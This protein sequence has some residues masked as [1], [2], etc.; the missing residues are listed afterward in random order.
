MNP[1]K[2]WGTGLPG[3]AV[4]IALGMS[5]ALA[6]TSARESAAAKTVTVRASTEYDRSGFWRT[7]FGDLWRD[8]W[9][10]E[11]TVP[12]LDLDHYAGGLT[13]LKEGGNQSKT[14]RF[15]GGDGRTYVFRSTTKR[16]KVAKGVPGGSIAQ[17]QTASI[18]PTGTLAVAVLQDAVGLLQA[19]PAMVYM[20]DDSRLGEFQKDFANTLGSIEVRPDEYE[21]GTVF[22][23]AKKIVGNESLLENLE[24]STEDRLDSR[25]YLKA[26]LIDFLIGDT[27][28]GSDQWSFAKF[29]LGKHDVYR[30]IPKDHDYAFLKVQGPIPAIARAVHP[31]LVCF[32]E[33][34]PTL[35]SLCYMTRD[36]DRS[37]LVDIEWDEWDAIAAQMQQQLGDD[38]IER[39]VNALPAGHRKTSGDEIAAALKARRDSLRAIA[40]EFYLMVN[41]EADI[42]ASD[43]NEQVDIERHPDGSVV[44]RLWH[45]SPRK[46]PDGVAASTRGG[47][48]DALAAG[49]ERRF[50]PEETR[51]IR[52]YLERGDDRAIV[53]GESER[54]IVV[55]VAGGEGDDVLADSSRV[56]R[57]TVTHFYDASGQN[58]FVRGDHTRI[59]TTPFVTAPPEHFDEEAKT[60]EESRVISEER[61]GRQR[62]LMQGNVT[63]LT[64]KAPDRY[65]GEAGRWTPT[66]G[67]RESGG[68]LLG[69]GPVY[70]RYGFRRQ[71]YAWRAG[72]HGLVGTRTGE[73][74]V[75]LTADRYYDSSRWSLALLTHATNLESNRFYGYG[76]DTPLLD[77][78]LTLVERFELLVKPS[79]RYRLGEKSS[80]EFGPVVKYV[81]PQL[82][83]GSPAA[84]ESPPGTEPFGQVGGRADLVLDRTV[85]DEK[86]QSGFG[87]DLGASAYPSAWDA[88][89][90]F[91][92]AHALARAFV[93]LGW[94]TLALRAGG[95]RSWG[96]FPLHESA[97][98]GGRWTVRGFRWNRFAGD[99][100]AF[101]SVELRVPLAS[102]KLF[103]RGQLG[104]LG[105]ADTGRVWL[106]GESDGDW[107]TGGGG[108][109]WFGNSERQASVA[110][111]YGDEHRIYFYMG[112]PF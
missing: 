36:F 14:L 5:P 9:S 43:E 55:R 66:T 12:V 65:W 59:V 102:L 56:G 17:D 67:Y 11:I 41:R 104:L 112:L 54:S 53:R 1:L 25:D 107:H 72:L 100:S 33:H 110:Y 80:L 64:A 10:A 38:V 62:D 28:R 26:R 93:P 90:A 57:K 51:E 94:P 46:E 58:T 24:E 101:G 108:G 86:K 19:E 7:L 77:E 18:H 69:F 106:D 15:R 61:R 91:G 76:N 16:I 52:V 3:S 31:R 37:H 29:E 34:Y 2:R 4:A 70:T 68:V 20:P 63:T 103:T 40:R 88:D 98:I 45:N 79:L 82:A 39:A 42:F 35:G 6:Q 99:T 73:L 97:F 75:R 50:V 109:L 30:P 74:G 84:I 105:F 95:Q 87:F 22:A 48:A 23:D 47:D 44:V 78:D 83:S 81:D 8:T 32:N 13:P 60:K 27:D 111:A 21:N 71:P 96:T 85:V 49:F 92:E 89:D